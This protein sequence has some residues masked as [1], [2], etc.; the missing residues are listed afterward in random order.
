QHLISHNKTI[1]ANSADPIQLENSKPATT[2]TFG[3]NK[4]DDFIIH[5]ISAQPKVSVTYNNIEI[6]SQLIGEYNFNNISVAIALGVYFKVEE[7]QI[8]EAI[9]TYVPKNNRSQIIEKGTTQIILDAYNANP[10]SMT[11]ALNNFG[12]LEA[13]NKIAI[14][15][16]M[17][18]LGKEAKAEH[19]AIA[20]LANSLNLSKV[21]F[22]GENFHHAIPE[23]NESYTSFD[24]FKTKFNFKTLENATLFI[25]GSRGMA[26]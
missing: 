3:Q 18:E 1:F 5:F 7:K 25:K 12:K 23:N 16:D 6:N 22:V 2:L 21:I 17:F 4:T 14:L 20:E 9:E 11:V 19:M 15:G 24:D 13:K 26:L 8:K 10:S